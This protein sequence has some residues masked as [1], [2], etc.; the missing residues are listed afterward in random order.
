MAVKEFKRYERKYLISTEKANNLLEHIT[1]RLV[2]DSFCKDNQKYSIYNIYFDTVNNDIVRR[3]CEKPYFKE[4]LRLRAYDNYYKTGKT[5]LE[6]KR[7]VGGIVI[8]RR[9][10]LSCAEALDFVGKGIK[11]EHPDLQK[12]NEFAYYFSLYPLV[13]AMFLAYDRTA[14]SVKEDP[15]VR[16]TFDTNIR[17]RRD[18]LSFDAGKHGDEL[19][20]ENYTILEIK[21]PLTTPLWIAK[22]LSAC[23]IYPYSY[24]KYGEA[25]KAELRRKYAGLQ[26]ESESMHVELPMLIKDG[27]LL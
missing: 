9:V 19:L 6:I 12:V 5:F 2:A 7:K 11:P 15:Q 10:D 13:P 16:I 22:E 18:N 3:S 1:D 8:K 14:F 27:I 25:Y 20:D 26:R 24:S 23:E 17:V 4:K 21:F